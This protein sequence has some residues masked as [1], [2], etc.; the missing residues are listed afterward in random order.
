M[1]FKKQNFKKISH[2]RSPDFKAGHWLEKRIVWGKYSYS[3]KNLAATVAVV[4]ASLFILIYF[5][6]WYRANLADPNK[7]IEREIR[8]LTL[9][10]G[11]TMELPTGEQPSLAT[12]S[13]KNKLKGQDFFSRAR[14]GDKLLIYSKARKAILY[15]PLEGK[16]IEVTNLTS[17]NQSDCPAIPNADPQASQ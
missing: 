8:S 7:A 13:D 9:K 11:R 15:R 2:F 14:N 1:E 12:V 3:L 6:S 16:I 4:L 5:I 10:I 17:G